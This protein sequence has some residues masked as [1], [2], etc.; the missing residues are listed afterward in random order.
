MIYKSFLGQK[1]EACKSRPEKVT[2]TEDL[3]EDFSEVAE[4]N[5]CGRWADLKRVG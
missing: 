3:L 5:A 4:P 2:I 1:A